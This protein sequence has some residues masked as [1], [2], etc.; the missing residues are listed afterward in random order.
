[1]ENFYDPF[2]AYLT[3]LLLMRKSAMHRS[4][5]NSKPALSMTIL[6]E[7]LSGDED[8]L[9]QHCLL[10]SDNMNCFKESSEDTGS[11]V[12]TALDPALMDKSHLERNL[13]VQ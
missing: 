5:N 1:M 13:V 3:T 9:D 7:E 11:P 10:A 8:S 6:T 12:A 4:E 2:L